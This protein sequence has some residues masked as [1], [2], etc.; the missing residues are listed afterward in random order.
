MV[1]LTPGEAEYFGKLAETA[2]RSRFE[3]DIDRSAYHDA[4]TQDGRPVESKT[5]RVVLANGRSG[6]WWIE[7]EAHNQLVHEDGLY[8]LS[9]YDPA[10][11]EAG[12]ILDIALVPATWVDELLSWTS[13]GYDHHKGEE[14]AKLGWPH[15]LDVEEE[16]VVVV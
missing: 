4:R 10:A 15:V 9:T 6:R 1:E 5:C 12:P 3:L 2:A 13:N 8:A 16:E 11:V 14:H 7:R